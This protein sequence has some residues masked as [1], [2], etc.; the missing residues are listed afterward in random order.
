MSN[1]VLS[2]EW[3]AG[4]ELI[5]HPPRRTIGDRALLQ[6]AFSKNMAV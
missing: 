3:T 4:A 5:Q 6:N 2:V 1:T